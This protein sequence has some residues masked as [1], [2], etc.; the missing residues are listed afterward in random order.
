MKITELKEKIDI[1]P[2]VYMKKEVF[3][4]KNPQIKIINK[5]DSSPKIY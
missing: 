2:Y 5:I 1:Q 3:L 4:T